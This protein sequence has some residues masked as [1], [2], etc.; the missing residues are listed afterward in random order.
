[1]SVWHGPSLRKDRYHGKKYYVEYE[2]EDEELNREEEIEEREES[3]DVF[4]KH[5]QF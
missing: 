4:R 5:C 2:E 3:G 1:M